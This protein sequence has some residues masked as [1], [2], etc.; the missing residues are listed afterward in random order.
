[1]TRL[2]IRF[3]SCL[4]VAYLIFACNHAD[5]DN[6]RKTG[7]AFFPHSQAEDTSF[8]MS[9]EYWKIWNPDVQAKIDADIEEYRKADAQ[10]VLDGIK[11][12]SEVKIEQIS[13]DFIFGAHIFNFN[14]LGKKEYNDRYK[15]LYGTLFNS[16]TVAF[17][18]KTF[19]TEPGRLRFREEYWDT[20]EYWNNCPDPMYQPHWRRPSTDQVVDFCLA[21]GIRVHGHTLIWGNRK[22]QSPDWL[23][24]VRDK[25]END[26]M[27]KMILETGNVGNYKD[28]DTYSSEY[29]SMTADEIADAFPQ[30]TRQFL[31]DFDNRIRR[32]AEHYGGRIQS[33]DV[34]N[35]SATDMASGA[36]VP[37]SR[38]SKSSYGL[39]PGDYPFRAFSVA[40]KS[41]PDYV[42]LN[43]NDYNLG[44]CYVDEVND[45]RNRGAR[46]DIMGSQMHLFN[47]QSCLDIAEGADIQTPAQVYDWYVRLS[48]AGL[49]IHLSEIT[50]TAPGDDERGWKIQAVIT[51]NLYRLWFSLPQMMG[52]TWWNVV[53]NCGAPGEPSISGL[54]TRDMQPKTSFFALDELI[55]NE[56][57]TN[58]TVNADKDGSVSFR[59]FKG[60]Y[61]IIWTDRRGRTHSTE[62]HLK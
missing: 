55:L 6:F 21:K 51:R 38:L 19:E 9:P 60:N 36:L 37:G 25:D 34:V 59:G 2:H 58:L 8:V 31:N 39:M 53:D 43:I 22:W 44:Q 26:R 11:P 20:E 5:A 56:W 18:W 33:W 32:I 29:Q 45:I 47:P 28:Y 17:Y 40:Q 16:A 50:I 48:K 4:F 3:F 54:F 42:K 61:R 14:Q 27:Q 1:M 35:E 24:N 57:R 15:E 46:I 30:F 52:I 13:S 49:P 41:F 12:G 23:F 10:I 62:Y 7:N